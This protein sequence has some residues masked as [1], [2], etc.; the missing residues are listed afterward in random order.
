[1]FG[2]TGKSKDL[3]KIC[4]I[5]LNFWDR[6]ILEDPG[7]TVQGDL[8]WT[9]FLSV[10][11]VTEWKKVQIRYYTF[12]SKVF[13]TIHA[14]IILTHKTPLLYSKTGVYMGIH[15]FSYFGKKT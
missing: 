10:K 7:Q 8:V 12:T 11:V 4:R 13:I 5:N 14:Y 2:Q 1:M 6:Q 15:Y 3:Q 9:C